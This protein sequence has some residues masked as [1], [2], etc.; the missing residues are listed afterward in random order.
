MKLNV[1]NNMRRAIILR[2][3][4]SCPLNYTYFNISNLVPDAVWYM[5]AIFTS[6][7]FALFISSGIT[8]TTKTKCSALKFCF[9]TFAMSSATFFASTMQK[10]STSLSSFWYS[11]PTYLPSTGFRFH[12][13][14]AG[15]RSSGTADI[16][17]AQQKAAWYIACLV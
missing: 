6:I 14:C 7:C 9:H 8:S 10:L 13:Q 17:W 2:C 5:L 15:E 4:N 1:N 3:D 12:P 11:N 16:A